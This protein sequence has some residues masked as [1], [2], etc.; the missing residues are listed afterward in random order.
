MPAAAAGGSLY[1]QLGLRRRVGFARYVY[2]IPSDEGSKIDQKQ[3]RYDIDNLVKAPLES[4]ET[5]KFK[6]GYTDY[7][8]AEIGDD[9]LPEVE[10]KNRSLETRFELTHKPVAGWHGTF[11]VQT[12]N[13]HF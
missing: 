10:F 4:F 11:G 8:H 3:T 9:G 5:F 13:T 7:E 12:E 1:R 2:G 6:A